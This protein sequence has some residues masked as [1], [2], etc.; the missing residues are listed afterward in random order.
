MIVAR[1]R[2]PF[3]DAAVRVIDIAENDRLRRAS[4]LAGC[5]DFAV[6]H[7]AVLLFGSNFCGIDALHAVRAFFH[8]AAAAYGDVGIAHAVEAG[9]GVI[10]IEQEIEAPDFVR[11]I[12]RAVA[13]ADAAV[14]NH[15]VQAF[16]AVH[17][18]ADGA[19]HFAGRVLTVH[20]EHRLVIRFG[21]VY[22]AAEISVHAD[23]VHRAAL[24]Y[25][26]L[27]DD[28]NI[29]FGLAGFDA[30]VAAHAF[31]QVHGQAPGVAFGFKARIEREALGGIFLVIFGEVCVFLPF[32]GGGDAD[33]V[34]A[35]GFHAFL[36][37]LLA[38]LVN[39][40]LV[41][42]DGEVIFLAGLFDFQSGDDPRCVGGANK[43]G[44]EAGAGA[45][46]A[47]AARNDHYA[48]FCFVTRELQLYVIAIGERQVLSGGGTDHRGIVPG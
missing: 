26:F 4:A 46:A 14:V 12:V 9:R 15:F 35:R 28:R 42:G 2:F 29:L 34:P 32:L 47:G 36:I 22:A 6:A 3:G 44:V 10:R 40:V 18:G 5:D 27:A 1:L 11:A 7:F 30:G 8:H 33:G 21:I 16:G 24:H 19:D 45:H 13:R 20:A 25:L 43:I 17:R 48:G 41:L 23:P 38:V 39:H 31:V 37:D